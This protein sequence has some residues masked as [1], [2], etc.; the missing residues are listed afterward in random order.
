MPGLFLILKIKIISGFGIPKLSINKSYVV[1]DR[2]DSDSIQETNYIDTDLIFCSQIDALTLIKL[3]ILKEVGQDLFASVLFI[4]KGYRIYSLPSNLY[5]KQI[6]SN[7]NTYRA[8]SKNH[9]Y[10]KMLS[11]IKKKIMKNLNLFTTCLLR[12]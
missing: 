9:G 7:A 3:K 2:Q 11:I 4:N 5:H 10:N 8:F 6:Q 1:A 12:T